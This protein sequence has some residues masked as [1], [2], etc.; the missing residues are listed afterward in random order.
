MTD[1]NRIFFQEDAFSNWMEDDLVADRE[2]ESADSERVSQAEID[3][4]QA[5]AVV[6]Q[7]E[8]SPGTSAVPKGEGSSAPKRQP[9]RGAKRMP[10]RME[11][12]RL[13]DWIH[14]TG[15]VIPQTS[16][17]EEDHLVL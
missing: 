10:L 6:S 1:N 8:T 5:S 13:H 4:V 12:L 15:E 3:N 17:E 14:G 2:T 11:D 16:N 7:P 9:G